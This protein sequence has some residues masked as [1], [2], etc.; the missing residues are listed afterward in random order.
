MFKLVD[1][2]RAWWPVRWPGVAEDGAIVQNEIEL[3]FR[4]LDADQV[5]ALEIEG[6]R[7]DQRVARLGMD[8]VGEDG[9]DRPE[10][11]AAIVSG[12]WADFLLRFTVDWRKVAAANGEPLPFSRDNLV[13]LVKV[14]GVFQAACQAFS[15][16][17]R[18]G[19]EIR[20]GN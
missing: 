8:A 13:R 19:A 12:E 7:V 15:V 17:V 11:P 16:C 3:Q 10:Q 20:K 1:E 14:N 18:G 4:L 5:A 6:I 9:S 2:Q